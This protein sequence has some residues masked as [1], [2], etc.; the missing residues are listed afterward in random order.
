[1]TDKAHTTNYEIAYRNLTRRLTKLHESAL[2]AETG[3]NRTYVATKSSVDANQDGV[4]NKVPGADKRL[5]AARVSHTAAAK[6]KDT[7]NI[8]V[9]ALELALHITLS[10][11]RKAHIPIE[12]LE[13][14]EDADRS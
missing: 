12:V 13:W 7:W 9:M 1:M 8:L 4:A 6:L 14:A 11:T 3:L 5:E 2:A 10:E